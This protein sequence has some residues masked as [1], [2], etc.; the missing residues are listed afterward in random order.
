MV[1]Y[2]N[3]IQK[4]EYSDMPLK[5]ILFDLDGTLLPMDQDVFTESYFRLLCKKM[6]ALGYDADELVGAVWQGTLAMM[7]NDGSRLNEEAF[8]QAFTGVYGEK[9][10]A[11]KPHFDEFYRTEFQ[12]AKSECGFDPAAKET[13]DR[14]KAAGYRAALATNPLFPATATESRIRWAGFEPED[15]ELYTTYENIGYCK[16]NP[17]YY[18]EVAKQ[19]NCEPEEC[20]MV[21]NDVN[22]DMAAAATGMKVFLLTDCLINRDKKDISLY[23]HGGFE[24]LLVYTESLA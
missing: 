14:L 12:L 23:P 17:E 2:E 13:A 24:D 18:R 8:W 4:R 7:K 1:Y 3:I 5:M 15:F 22:D 16:P 10:M 6:A 9:A 20:L 19:L 21:V 11:D